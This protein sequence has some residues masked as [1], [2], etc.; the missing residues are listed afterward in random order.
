[1]TH[2]QQ[3]VND[4][5]EWQVSAVPV[6]YLEA[7]DDQDARAAAIASGL[8]RERFW[9]LE[10][11]PLITAGTSAREAD[12][13]EPDRFPLFRSPRGGQYTYHGPGQRIVYVQL[14]LGRRGRD[15]RAFVC[16]L[17][18]WIIAVLAAFDVRGER[19]EGRVGV[20]V[21][22]PRHGEAKIAA[23]GV[24]VRRWVTLHGLSL[25]VHP[26]LSH[27]DAIVPCGIRDF[28]VTSLDDL[29]VSVSLEEVDRILLATMPAMVASI[30]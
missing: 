22:H 8:A 3:T 26:Q 23:I 7:S 9:L 25:N 20:W 12:L 21:A 4:A 2:A 30:G 24:R 5:P 28:G 17:E 14:D 10:H 1:M 11:P 27:F 16:A 6:P 19:R 15:V 29:G 13:V 18:N